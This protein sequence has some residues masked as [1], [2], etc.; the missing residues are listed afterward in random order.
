MMWLAKYLFRWTGDARFGDYYERN[1]YNGILSGHH[2]EQGVFTYYHP[3]APGSMK[4]W[5]SRTEHFWCC[6]GTGVQAISE[7]PNG[8]YFHREN[9]IL[10]NLFVPSTLSW[11]VQGKEVHVTQSAMF[12]KDGESRLSIRTEEPITF[13]LS[14]RIPWWA[15]PDAKVLI[16]GKVTG[17]DLETPSVW[18]H[19]RRWEDGDQVEVELPMHVHSEPLPDASE[20]VAVMYGPLALA[21]MAEGDVLISGDLSRPQTWTRRENDRELMFTALAA[22]RQMYAMR[23]IHEIIDEPYTLYLTVG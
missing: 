17:Q 18:V 1:F 11:Q 3:F 9:E 2:V 10:V 23:P 16:N 8:I 12:P 15:G 6:Y 19:E 21:A 7:I 14:I 22:D 20:K 5:D 4:R 13:R